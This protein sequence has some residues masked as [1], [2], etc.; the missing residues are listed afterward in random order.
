M[1]ASE[2][3]RDFSDWNNNPGAELVGYLYEYR[4][5]VPIG[6]LE[7]VTERALSSIRISN[8]PYPQYYFLEALCILRLAARIDEPFKT[9]IINRIN[10]DIFEIIETDQI[11]WATTYSA[12]PFFFA[13]AP[14]GPIFDSIKDHVLRSLENEI[15]TQSDEGNFILNW[16]VQD[17]E[18]SRT[19][20]SIWT[21]EALRALHHHGMIASI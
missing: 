20:K 17:E 13:H 12:K 14:I 1:L 9:E 16:S 21:L 2:A 4:E 6:F 8:K 10:A 15:K 18:S 7:T 19:W 11:K 5:L 3:Q